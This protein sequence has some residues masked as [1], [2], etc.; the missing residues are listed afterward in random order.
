MAKRFTDTTKWQDEW[1]MDLSPKYK[2]LWLFL[3]DNCDHAG[4]WKVNLKLASFHI[5]EKFDKIESMKVFSDRILEFKSGYWYVTKFV[6]FQYGGFKNDAV[7]KS[8]QKIL[9]ANELNGA[10]EDHDRG[11]IAP[12]VKDKVKDKDKDINKDIVIESGFFKKEQF[13]I[14]PEQYIISS[15]EQMKIQKNITISEQQIIKMWDIFKAQQL[16][17]DKYYNSKSDVYR[18]F[19][20]WVKNQ[21]FTQDV[22][23]I[24]SVS[25]QRL[26]QS[27]EYLNRYSETNSTRPKD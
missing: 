6:Q 23:S 25:K 24:S 15:I 8:I 1:F 2:L 3:L 5:G 17:G 13:D 7:G 27:I 9:K 20:N 26:N 11:L 22:K 12:K 10:I 19:S 21:K 4:I 18:H 16:A 14:L